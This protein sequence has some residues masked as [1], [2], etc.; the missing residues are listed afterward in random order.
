MLLTRRTQIGLTFAV[1]AAVFTIPSKANDSVGAALDK[2][3]CLWEYRLWLATSWHRPPEFTVPSQFTQAQCAQAAK[4]NEGLDR[5]LAESPSASAPPMDLSKLCTD[6]KGTVVEECVKHLALAN[7][8]TD[9]FMRTASIE[10]AKAAFNAQND[11]LLQ[12]MAVAQ[13]KQEQQ[14]AKRKAEEKR[15][16]DNVELVRRMTACSLRGVPLGTLK[17]GMSDSDMLECG[18]GKPHNVNVTVDARGRLEQWVYGSVY[19]YF[20]NGV[21][22]SYQ[23]NR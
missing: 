19:A 12:A 20:Q 23:Q 4:V 9:E 10:R 21:L 2:T 17:L 14:A 16:R 11:P 22:R 1:V 6:L 3:P 18:L 15:K 13:E 5:A 8:Q 7:E